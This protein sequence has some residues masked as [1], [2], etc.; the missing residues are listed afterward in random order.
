MTAFEDR[1][2]GRGRSQQLAIMLGTEP[3]GDLSWW[4][5][6]SSCETHQTSS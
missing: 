3:D 6:L 5:G 2:A 1:N 4:D